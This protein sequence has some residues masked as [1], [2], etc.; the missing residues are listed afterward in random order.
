L[1]V[2]QAKNAVNALA[3]AGN[4]KEKTRKFRGIYTVKFI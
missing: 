2:I 4:L 3:K 1:F